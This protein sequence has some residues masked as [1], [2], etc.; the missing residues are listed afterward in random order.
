MNELS[1]C[2]RLKDAQLIKPSEI[3]IY[4][5]E[6]QKHSLLVKKAQLTDGGIY[7]VKAINVAGELVANARLIVNGKGNLPP[8]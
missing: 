6:G 7:S 4:A 8:I 3:A 2:F 5:S 1:F